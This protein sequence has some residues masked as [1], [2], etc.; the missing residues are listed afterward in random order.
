MYFDEAIPPINADAM[1]DSGLTDIVVDNV[2]L[3]LTT[4]S[5][6]QAHICYA[7][8]ASLKCKVNSDYEGAKAD[9]LQCIQLKPL[10]SKVLHA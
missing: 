8:R 6:A 3:M 9:C 4:L 2:S 1:L 7:N 10:Y 5:M